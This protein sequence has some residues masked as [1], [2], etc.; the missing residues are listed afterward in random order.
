M[1]DLRGSSAHA[2]EHK[3]GVQVRETGTTGNPITEARIAALEARVAV[4]EAQVG[5][6]S[7]A[8]QP[9]AEQPE[10]LGDA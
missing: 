6:G 8:P 4:L 3:H 7:E 5:T 9:A 10:T 2:A 1:A